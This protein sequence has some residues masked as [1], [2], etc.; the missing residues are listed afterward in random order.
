MFLGASPAFDLA[1][2]STCFIREANNCQINAGRVVSNVQM[3]VV[4]NQAS[5]GKVVTAYP[6]NVIRKIFIAII[7]NFLLQVSL[8][9]KQLQHT[10]T[11]H[12]DISINCENRGHAES[13]NKAVVRY[14]VIW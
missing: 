14:N 9:H 1:M 3:T 13:E 7:T 6:T 8:K 11:H 5:P 12:W 10:D 4:E 2:F